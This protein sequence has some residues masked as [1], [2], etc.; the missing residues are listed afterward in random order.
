MTLAGGSA[1]GPVRHIIV[2]LV[3][4]VLAHAGLTGEAG[5]RLLDQVMKERRASQ[6]ADC[7]LRFAARAGELEVT[8]SQSGRD[9]RTTC[10]V[11]VR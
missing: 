2:D 7:V 10:P 11:P 1:D 8:L 9:W 6:S 3:R 5:E 4:S